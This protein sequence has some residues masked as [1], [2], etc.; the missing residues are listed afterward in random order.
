MTNWKKFPYDNTE[1]EFQDQSLEENW[2][3]LHSGDGVLY[4]DGDW[5]REQLEFVPQAA[6]PQFNGDIT[7][8]TTDLQSAWRCFHSGSFQQAV[9]L[10]DR[11]GLLAHACAN[12]AT[13]IHASYLQEDE[14]IQQSSFLAAIARAEQAISVFPADANAHYFRAFN[15]GRYGQS[16]SIVEALKR[17]MA[18]KIH[19]SLSQ[20]LQQ[21][22]GHAEAHTA[23]GMYHAEIINKVGKMIGRMTYGTSSDKALQHFESAVELTPDSP[24]AHIEYGNGLYLLFGD[25]KLDEVT[26]LYI[27]ATEMHPLDAMEKLD[28]E[29]ALA[30][31]E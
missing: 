15:L 11:C 5:V 26:D 24:I 13:G 18:G 7:Q 19:E 8:L 16:I 29:A 17:G 3:A 2:P 6:P 9:E 27:R 1:F 4:P 22:P 30:E 28:I 21:A 10:S 14:P 12:K 20:T 31:L 25:K 23:M